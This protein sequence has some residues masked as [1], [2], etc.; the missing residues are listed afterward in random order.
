MGEYKNLG[1]EFHGASQSE[2]YE[3]VQRGRRVNME[4]ED[5]GLCGGVRK[6]MSGGE[7]EELRRTSRTVCHRLVTPLPTP[8]VKERGV[9]WGK[10]KE[11]RTDMDK[12]IAVV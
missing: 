2:R 8:S 11:R 3:R 1:R 7:M 12:M 6:D 4:V 9:S 10:P 5:E